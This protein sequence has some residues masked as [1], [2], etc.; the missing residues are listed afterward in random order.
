[1]DPTS[2]YS[3]SGTCSWDSNGV[4]FEVNGISA[5]GFYEGLVEEFFDIQEIYFHI[6][7]L[8]ELVIWS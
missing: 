1:M 7:R 8:M 6:L 2:L 4:A 5:S 3:T